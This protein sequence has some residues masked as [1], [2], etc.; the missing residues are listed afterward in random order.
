[1][2]RCGAVSG[3]EGRVPIADHRVLEYVWNIPWP[4]KCKDGVVK[5]MLRAAGRGWL[6]DSVLWRAKSPFP[7]TYDPA[8][9]A[10]L[11]ERMRAL[12]ASPNEPL[13]DYVDKA[14][15]EAFLKAPADY[16]KPWY[17][18]LMAAPQRVGWFLQFNGW[19]R[20][21]F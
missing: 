19:L 2:D 13:H 4:L 12:L 6:P 18:Q 15:A 11:A 7:K 20:E 21:Y 14:K 8:Y 1:M 16:G 9:E 10:L 3:L 5:Y 17:G